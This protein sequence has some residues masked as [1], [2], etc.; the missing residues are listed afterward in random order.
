MHSMLIKKDDILRD[1]VL[2]LN[3]QLKIIPKG[4][5]RQLSNGVSKAEWTDEGIIIYFEEK[6]DEKL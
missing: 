4:L 5:N 1:T 2:G 6:E 3:K